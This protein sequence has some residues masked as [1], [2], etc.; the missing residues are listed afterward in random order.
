MGKF[1]IR[2][3]KKAQFYKER[4]PLWGGMRRGEQASKN[5]EK[6]IL[7]QPFAMN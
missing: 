3:I 4:M 6:L 1:T 2:G 5:R 7:S